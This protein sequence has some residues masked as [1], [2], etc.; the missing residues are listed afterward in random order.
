[1]SVFSGNVNYLIYEIHTGPININKYEISLQSQIPDY[2]SIKEFAV[3]TDYPQLYHP[4]LFATIFPENYY[5]SYQF[6]GDGG[7]V[8]F[9][10]NTNQPQKIIAIYIDAMSGGGITGSKIMGD[11][12]AAVFSNDKAENTIVIN[13]VLI[14]QIFDTLDSGDLLIID[15]LFSEITIKENIGKIT[16]VDVVKIYKDR[17]FGENPVYIVVICLDYDISSAIQNTYLHSK[18]VRNNCKIETQY[19][20]LNGRIIGRKSA[21]TPKMADGVYMAVDKKLNQMQKGVQFK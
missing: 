19:Y 18:S 20:N 5:I 13:N 4:V 1:M 9:I 12:S 10:S 8:D 6:P 3:K 11:K 21:F 17:H 2:D 14:N 7:W 15:T 16:D